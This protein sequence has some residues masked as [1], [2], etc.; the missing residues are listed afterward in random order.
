M[1]P[2]TTID[3]AEAAGW[4]GLQVRCKHETAILPWA[5]IRA[6]TRRVELAEIAPR[7]RPQA[8]GCRMVEVRLHRMVTRVLNGH[9]EA[10]TAPLAAID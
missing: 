6:S 1:P 3:D 8:C 5:K 4:Q 9:P 2:L 10:E 7:L